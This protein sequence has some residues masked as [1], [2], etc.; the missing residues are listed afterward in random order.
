MLKQILWI[1]IGDGKHRKHVEAKGKR[2]LLSK[3]NI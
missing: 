2:R 3:I 1:T